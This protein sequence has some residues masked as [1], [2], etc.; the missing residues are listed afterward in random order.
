MAPG[1]GLLAA[2]LAGLS[3]QPVVT[4]ALALSATDSHQG[5]EQTGTG[6]LFLTSRQ[7]RVKR[8]TLS[9][10]T[11]ARTAEISVMKLDE[12]DTLGWAAGTAGQEEVILIVSNGQAIRFS[13]EEV[14]P[15][16]L[17]AAGVLGVK[18]G[19]DDRVVGMGIYRPRG[20]VI[21]VSEMG[22]GKRS[23]LSE[24][25]TQGRYGAGV[26]TA[27][28]SAKTG[29]LTAGAVA[30]A[31]DRLLMVSEKGNNKAVYV[32]SLPKARRATQGKELI[33]IRGRDRLTTLLLL[34][35]LEAEVVKPA[36]REAT[37]A[38]TSRV[39]GTG[40]KPKTSKAQSGSKA[41]TSPS[42]SRKKRSKKR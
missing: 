28:L 41:T 6:Y 20:D 35:P 19:E 1:E 11:A 37:K 23:A 39:S 8:V 12:G 18:M 27:N 2:E 42:A 9:D 34:S 36:S 38:R 29:Q 7:G 16:G 25:P 13:E 10:L 15:M 21:V 22:V 26:A 4:A 17:P 31:S 14:R 32:R 30:S 40:K 24:Y 33:A 3:S 5:K